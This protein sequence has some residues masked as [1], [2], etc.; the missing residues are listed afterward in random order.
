MSSIGPKYPSD[1]ELRPRL[2]QIANLL[3]DDVPRKTIDRL[4]AKFYNDYNVDLL[5][6]IDPAK[7]F[8]ETFPEG[9][10]F[11]KLKAIAKAQLP[12][13]PPHARE[14]SLALILGS[15][16]KFFRSLIHSLIKLFQT[17][18]TRSDLGGL[19]KRR[20]IIET[21]HKQVT[22][23]YEKVIEIGKLPEEMEDLVEALDDLG[24]QIAP[25]L[26]EI[27]EL[28]DSNTLKEQT[29]RKEISLHL[30]PLEKA[31]F[32]ACIGSLLTLAKA[33]QSHLAEQGHLTKRQ[34]DVV[35]RDIKEIQRQKE[36]A[37]ES[38]DIDDILAVLQYAQKV[39]E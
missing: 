20:D 32:S 5:K 23:L 39:L 27:D 24:D 16:V 22:A 36:I 14:L 2:L 10:A 1:A 21:A 31:I 13:V 38:G 35:N 11:A 4:I 26:S 17:S 30:Y 29:H 15:V 34:I 6:G 19:Q 12:P 28:K 25:L 7:K 18:I 9:Q 33:F 3:R 37:E 8:S